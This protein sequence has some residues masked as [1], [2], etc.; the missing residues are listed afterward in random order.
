AAQRKTRKRPLSSIK[1]IS[2]IDERR[3]VLLL[4]HLPPERRLSSIG[5][6]SPF[7][8][9]QNPR[10]RSQ[11]PHPVQHLRRQVVEHLPFHR[12]HYVP[13]P[14]LQSRFHLNRMAPQ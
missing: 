3:R 6:A 8:Q 14:E 2:L 7:I 1:A 13:R 9:R 4:P 12:T 11:V 5:I 10:K